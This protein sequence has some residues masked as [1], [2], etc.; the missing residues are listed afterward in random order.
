MK[1]FKVRCVDLNGRNDDTYTVG[2]VYEVKNG[3]LTADSDFVFSDV[4]FA[5]VDELNRWSYSKFEL[6]TEPQ[7]F[8]KDMLKTGM[9]VET[10]NGYQFMVLLGTES[11]DIFV[12]FSSDW[13]SM[14]NYSKEL[15][16]KLDGAWDVLRVYTRESPARSLANRPYTIL[17]Q[18]PEPRKINK[19]EAEKLLSEHLEELIQIE[20]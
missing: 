1:D 13:L 7:Q 15:K 17:W 4:L 5:N 16:H 12:N 8:T 11:G 6:V 2:K 10:K 18:R 14:V 9:W 20:G 19:A 3:V